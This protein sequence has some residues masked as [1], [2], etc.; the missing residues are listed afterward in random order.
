M[1]AGWNGDGGE[2]ESCCSHGGLA[3]DD[4]LVKYFFDSVNGARLIF[5]TLPRKGMLLF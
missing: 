5:I 3:E 2:G 4:G 1:C